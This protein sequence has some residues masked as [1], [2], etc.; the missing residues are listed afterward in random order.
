MKKK[1]S[2]ML[3][4]AL[5]LTMF[6]SVIVSH[7]A[8]PIVYDF[9]T[10]G[11]ACKGDELKDDAKFF[12]KEKRFQY[13]YANGVSKLIYSAVDGMN[14][15][16]ITNPST[17][18]DASVYK[19]VKIAYWTKV[20]AAK[21][22]NFFFD[23]GNGIIGGNNK[24][25]SIT[26]DGSWQYALID[27][28]D[29]AT[30]TGTIKQIRY[31]FLYGGE[32]EAGD[33]VYCGYIALFDSADAANNYNVTL[34]DMAAFEEGRTEEPGFTLDNTKYE[35]TDD[36]SIKL[37]FQNA[38]TAGTW[39]GI[40]PASAPEAIS[41]A[42]TIDVWCYTNN[43]R[44]L[45]EEVISNGTITL[46]KAICADFTKLE[47]GDYKVVMFKADS[48]ADVYTILDTK[49]FSFVEEGTD[50]PTPTPP[51]TGDENII[52]ATAI[53]AVIVAATIVCYRKQKQV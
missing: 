27:M 41:G 28:S 48:G 4:L 31:D 40:Y 38:P 30:W 17:N 12:G 20:S 15:P 42:D 51:P 10:E 8:D 22:M 16:Y 36:F 32:F 35:L 33:Y 21:T 53:F 7:A 2:L 49:T 1:I 43:T 26:A 19:F 11:I 45:P 46:S 6:A 39:F 23:N 14:N 47:I 3:A 52:I 18:I 37:T 24:E 9:T 34:P 44:E 50:I 25:A 13:D 5:A 29:V